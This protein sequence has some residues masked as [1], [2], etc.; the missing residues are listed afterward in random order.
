M[1]LVEIHDTEDRPITSVKMEHAPRVG[2]HLWM[3]P[4]DGTKPA[5]RVTDVAHWVSDESEYHK[6]CVHVESI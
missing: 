4:Q 3:L 2:E 6:V 5:Y 1:I